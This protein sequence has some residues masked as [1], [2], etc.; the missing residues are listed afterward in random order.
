[1]NQ[2]PPMSRPDD[3]RGPMGS[4]GNQS[5]NFPPQQGNFP[6]DRHMGG[7]YPPSYRDRGPGATG[8]GENNEYLCCIS[9]C[10]MQFAAHEH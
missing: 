4:Y 3:Y 6:G 2:Q 5:G 7:Q 8:H 9:R 10:T 1:M